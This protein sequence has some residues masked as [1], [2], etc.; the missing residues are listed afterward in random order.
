MKNVHTPGR[1][2]CLLSLAFC[3]CGT[4]RDSSLPSL[5]KP[6]WAAP[7]P[8]QVQ[9]A[10]QAQASRAAATRPSPASSTRGSTRHASVLIRGVPHVR[11]RPDF[12]GEACV[13]MALRSQGHAVTQDDFFAI[14][15]INPALGRGALA[16]ELVRGLRR[17]G[18]DPG[19]VWFGVRIKRPGPDVAAQ[20]DRLHADLLRGIPSI[21]GTYYDSRP[22]S[23]QHFRL[24]LGYDQATDEV[25]YHE[26][27]E[28]NGAHRRIKRKL[29]LALWP[30]SY[31]PTKKILIRIPLKPAAVSIPKKKS[32]GRH[33]AA[34][35]AQHVMQLRQTTFKKLRGNFKVRIQPPFVVVGDGWRGD[36]GKMSA[37]IKWVSGELKAKYFARDPE[38][39][40]TVWLFKNR[41]SYLT[42]AIRLTGEHPG[43]PFGFYSSRHRALIMNIRTGGGTLSH[44]IVHPFMEANFPDCPPWLNEGMGSL[45]EAVSGDFNKRIWGGVNWR[46]PGLQ[47]AIRSKSVPSFAALLA[48]NEHQFYM[49]DPGT[50]YSQ[51][52][53]L[54][55]YLQTHGLLRTYY[56]RFYKNR[57]SDPT[58]YKT[59]QKVLGTTDMA[60]FKHKWEAYVI[61]L[62]W[63]RR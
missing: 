49:R 60:A 17:L 14:A 13:E 40:L 29:F 22:N 39:V 26:P 38:R 21:I 18:H 42:N 9:R 52:R 31:K 61:K 10:P 27:A 35:Y 7:P 63:P 45:Y 28:A 54:V 32:S 19:K 33:S 58:G 5:V 2:V 55:Y 62:K 50:N 41:R 15:G 46:L 23:T 47:Q 37:F 44:E 57:R 59:L 30:L 34:D 6:A 56:H 4:D 11:Q 20:F 43:T 36:L 25:I 24:V 3:G 12:C 51:S 48:Q 1:L 16:K 53:Y 8:A